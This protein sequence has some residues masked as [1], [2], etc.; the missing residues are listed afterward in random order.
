MKTDKNELF[1]NISTESPAIKFGTE[2]KLTCLNPSPSSHF[3]LNGLLSSPG[4]T[5]PPNG[6]GYGAI[7]ETPTAGPPMGGSE[8]PYAGGAPAGGYPTPGAGVMVPT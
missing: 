1:D 5:A 2:Y 8:P 7:D 4:Y 6:G 3:T